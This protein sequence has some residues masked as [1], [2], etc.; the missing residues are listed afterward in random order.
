VQA[1]DGRD[2]CGDH[3]GFAGEKRCR[4]GRTYS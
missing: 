1:T 2:G 4:V 3:F